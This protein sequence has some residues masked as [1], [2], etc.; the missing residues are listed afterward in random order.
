MAEER[1]RDGEQTNMFLS[2]VLIEFPRTRTLHSEGTCVFRP[3]RRTSLISLLP[4]LLRFTTL[5]AQASSNAC[6]FSS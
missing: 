3:Q 2:S 4:G 5:T 6:L 1:Y